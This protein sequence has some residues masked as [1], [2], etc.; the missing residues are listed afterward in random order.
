MH[1]R[2]CGIQLDLTEAETWLVS[3]W[4][5]VAWTVYLIYLISEHKHSG[6]CELTTVDLE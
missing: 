5:G 1:L 6:H 2:C 3:S 4:C